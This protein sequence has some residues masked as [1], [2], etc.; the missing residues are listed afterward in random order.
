MW[1]VTTPR[2]RSVGGGEKDPKSGTTE[3][4]LV[5]GRNLAANFLLVFVS[6]LFKLQRVF[7]LPALGACGWTSVGVCV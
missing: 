7:S 6:F 2:C 4:M 3:E 1:V 5:Y